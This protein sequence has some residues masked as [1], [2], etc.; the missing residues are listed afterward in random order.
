MFDHIHAHA[1]ILHDE[2][3]VIFWLLLTPLVCLLITL[4][5]LKSEDKGPNVQDLIK[6]HRINL[7]QEG[8]EPFF[9]DDESKNLGYSFLFSIYNYNFLRHIIH[10]TF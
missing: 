9:V 1:A 7:Y 2:M 3:K 6:E 8:I 10:N 4:E 5:V